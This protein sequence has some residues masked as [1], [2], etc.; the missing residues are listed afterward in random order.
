MPG[1]AADLFSPDYA[2][3]RDRFRAT[4]HGAGVRLDSLPLAATGPA[5]E[6]LTIDVAWLGAGDARRIL[7]HTSGLHGVEAFAGS[8]IQEALLACPPP[9][10][11][12]CALIL[13]H[14]LN[15]W[16]M[17]WLRRTDENNVDL[18]RNFLR[19]GE[20]WS[21]VPEAYRKIDRTLNPRS[22]SFQSLVPWGG[23]PHEQVFIRYSRLDYLYWQYN[24]VTGLYDRYQDT[25]DD[26]GQGE[27][28][29]PLFD[30]YTGSQISAA[31]VVILM[32]SHEEF[33]NSSDTEVIKI[34]IEGA[35][36]GY[37]FRDGQAYQ[38]TWARPQIDLPLQIFRAGR[39]AGAHLPLKPGTTFFQVIGVTTEILQ[40]EDSWRFNFSIP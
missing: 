11:A 5:D 25:E 13:V 6:A 15:P 33:V 16:G 7:L 37:L 4:A 9:L 24:P 32:V 34:N 36:S 2:T 22:P 12:G 20:R 30:E 23:E 39:G 17:A 1:D 27:S 31:N 19:Q 35:G 10:P 8:A 38:I 26:E 40:E 14:I 28:Y 3:A 21:G 29:A 18:N